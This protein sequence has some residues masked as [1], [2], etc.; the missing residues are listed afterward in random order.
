MIK[1]I[2]LLW[3]Q[4]FENSP[5]VVKRCRESWIKHNPEWKIIFLDQNNLHE[6][7]DLKDYIP[8]IE[9][10]EISLTHKSDIIRLILLHKYGG[11][12]TDATTF[13]M[14]PLDG[15]MIVPRKDFLPLIDLVQIG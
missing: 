8:D 2:Y 15:S 10:K 5:L 12:W 14:K 9:K 11:L 6:Y 1:V 7:L 13:C 4:E 3:F